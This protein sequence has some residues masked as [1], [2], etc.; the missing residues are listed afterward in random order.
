MKD[1]GRPP[2]NAR[3]YQ[4]FVSYA[5][6]D[7]VFVASLV[8]R[9]TAAGLYVWWDERRLPAS[10]SIAFELPD[11]IGN[12]TAALFVISKASARSGWV[13]EE[14][15][16][17]V[18]QRTRYANYRIQTV[19]LDE[20]EPP[21]LLRTTRWIEAP[22]AALTSDILLDLLL[23]LYGPDEG[24]VG[25]AWDLYVSRSWKPK[26]AA[27]AD[28][29][30]RHAAAAGYRLIGDAP[31]QKEFDEKRIGALIASCGAMLAIAPNRGGAT[32][33]Y[34][35]EEAALAG[36][37]GVPCVIVAEDGVKLSQRT[38]AAAGT[39]RVMSASALAE[40]GGKELLIGLIQDAHRP[41]LKP[42]Y[43]FYASS[44]T[45]TAETNERV[46]RLVE[47]VT[48][49]ECVMGANMAEQ[50]AQLAIIQSIAGALFMLA[51][52][53]DDNRNTLIE[54]GIA[55]GAGTRL[56]L[57]AAG[58][59]PQQTRFMFRDMEVR[60]YA[61]EPDLLAAVHRVARP[62]RRRVLNRE[63]APDA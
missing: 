57:F 14:F 7:R 27:T 53:S 23:G 35:E 12:A 6:E 5:H 41:P 62:Y 33:P 16:A 56:Y 20:T 52:I 22:G 1:R 31:D 29:V 63:L 30:C 36:T 54:A 32:S 13:K 10:A 25:S 21:A 43:V 58:S 26:E 17:A 49:I 2:L 44:L 4:L 15:S 8:Q 46:R 37:L 61:D 40:S 28:A 18:D 60:F 51:D 47:R 38:V 55:R 39:E 42:H 45:K 24:P 50:H 48:G 59:P 3:R 19:R 34:I 11:A 9:L